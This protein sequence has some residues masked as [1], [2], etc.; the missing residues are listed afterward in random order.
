[1]D[2]DTGWIREVDT[3]VPL[4]DLHLGGKAFGSSRL[5]CR[6]VAAVPTFP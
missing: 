5:N 6:S 4:E 1:M 3:V 2:L